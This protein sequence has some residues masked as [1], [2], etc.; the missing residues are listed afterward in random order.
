MSRLFILLFSIIALTG[1]TACAQAQDAQSDIAVSEDGKLDME[2]LLKEAQ[3][4]RDASAAELEQ[5]KAE[6]AQKTLE[7]KRITRELEALQKL[8]DIG[9]KP[10]ED[11]DIDALIADVD[12]K[13]KEVSKTLTEEIEETEREKA[14]TER[15]K[16]KTAA[17]EEIAKATREALN[18]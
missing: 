3:E 18:D 5:E 15:D 9:K 11:F 7:A 12:A 1:F 14:E 6:T 2:A 13:D 10:N 16:A 4:K 17:L 8:I